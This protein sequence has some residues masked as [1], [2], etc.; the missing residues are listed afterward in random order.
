M[1]FK[2]FIIASKSKILKNQQID[3]IWYI[4]VTPDI[5][6]YPGNFSA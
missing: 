1:K 3:Y 5:V 4:Y 6:S 2:E